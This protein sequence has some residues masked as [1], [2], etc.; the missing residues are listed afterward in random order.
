M[1][2]NQLWR[3]VVDRKYGVYRINGVPLVV[4]GSYGVGVQ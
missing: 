3:K 1:D 4:G 2:R